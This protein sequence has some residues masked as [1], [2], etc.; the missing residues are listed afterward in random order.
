MELTGG[1]GGSW[2]RLGA[3]LR[4][5]TFFRIISYTRRPDNNIDS[6]YT[7]YHLSKYN[8]NNDTEE[9][10][11]F[12]KHKVEIKS[13]NSNALL[14]AV[15]HPPSESIF[16]PNEGDIVKYSTKDGNQI[17]II[18]AIPTGLEVF[19]IKISPDHTMLAIQTSVNDELSQDEISQGIYLFDMRNKLTHYI[20]ESN[21]HHV[22]TF[23][24]NNN[25]LIL[26]RPKTSEENSSLLI[27][28]LGQKEIIFN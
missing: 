21:G 8:I 25:F 23:S 7:E 3:S 24:D 10:F 6:H 19:S 17:G 13:K 1:V 4:G 22:H 5:H 26:G 18:S 16:L 9:N 27:Y 2:R 28:D 14:G 15:F 12:A 20:E 11:L